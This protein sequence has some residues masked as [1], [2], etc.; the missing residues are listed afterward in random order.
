MA[1]LQRLLHYMLRLIWAS[2]VLACSEAPLAEGSVAVG[3]RAAAEAGG[4]TAEDCALAALSLLCLS[5]QRILADFNALVGGPGAAEQAAAG[6]AAP[7]QLPPA[8]NT[9]ADFRQKVEEHFVG[10]A[11]QHPG[12]IFLLRVL[13]GQESWVDGSRRDTSL[14]LRTCTAAA[15]AQ[16]QQL[17]QTVRQHT[18]PPGQP[19]QQAAGGA[20][21]V[22]TAASSAGTAEGRTPAEDVSPGQSEQQR[23]KLQAK[24]RQQKMLARMRAQQAKA[25]AALLEEEMGSE[26]PQEGPAPVGGLA[27][28]SPPQQP[29]EPE[30][31]AMEVDSQQQQA[32]ALARAGQGGAVPAVPAHHPAAWEQCPGAECALCH[33]GSEAAPLGLVAQ[34]QVTE[35]PMLA[36]ADGPSRLAPDRPGVPGSAI[37]APSDEEEERGAVAEPFPAAGGGPRLSVFDRQPSMH[38]LCC[39]HMLHAA[40]LERYR[41]AKREG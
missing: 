22:G 8:W 31:A 7:P 5:L 35:L 32:D 37:G 1:G 9:P 19:G 18:E 2:L 16:V 28:A 34:L 38:L 15:A 41:R 36:S 39:G 27:P 12:I 13:A 21:T 30:T 11:P 29:A 40:C 10:S 33:S 14:E 23:R 24:Q 17:L 4:G 3:S 20:G 26:A 25:A 6:H